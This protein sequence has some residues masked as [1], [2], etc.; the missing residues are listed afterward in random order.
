[1]R[2]WLCLGNLGD[3]ARFA[4]RRQLIL[5]KTRLSLKGRSA[6]EVELRMGRGS[7]S[8]RKGEIREQG[9]R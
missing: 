9:P 3:E 7:K 6:E 4:R 8:E 2:L 5:K 1:M